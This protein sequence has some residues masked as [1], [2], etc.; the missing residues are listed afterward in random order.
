MQIAR[1]NAQIPQMSNNRNKSQNVSNN[2]KTQTSF[3]RRTQAFDDFILGRAD[4]IE[5]IKDASSP[6]LEMLKKI[7]KHPLFVDIQNNSIVLKEYTAW[8]V[9]HVA[10]RAHEKT[11]SIISSVAANMDRY[12]YLK[13]ATSKKNLNKLKQKVSRLEKEVEFKKNNL[14]KNLLEGSFSEKAKDDY[15]STFEGLE[16]ARTELKTR[17]DEVSELELFFV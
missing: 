10:T 1:M 7:K 5:N 11:D 4:I 14:N 8:K 3:G 6:L 16:S 12:D 13:T 15:N 17:E 9:N 2:Q